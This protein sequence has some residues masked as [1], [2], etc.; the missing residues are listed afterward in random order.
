MDVSNWELQPSWK[1]IGLG[2][3]SCVKD[4]ALSPG[5]ELP[6]GGFWPGRFGLCGEWNANVRR[7]FR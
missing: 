4:F 3:D 6:D 5:R 1:R 7:R 2:R